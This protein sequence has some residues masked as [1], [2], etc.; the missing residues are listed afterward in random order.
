MKKHC[1]IFLLMAI[2]FAGHA[3]TAVYARFIS[4]TSQVLK[5]DGSVASGA[6]I[7]ANSIDPSSPELFKITTLNV[8]VEQT[9]NIGSQAT[10]A[11]AGKITFNPLSFSRPVDGASPIFFQNA[12]SGTPY[13]TIEVF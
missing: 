8:D 13:R 5:T 7:T 10:G 12:A 6:L 9:L 11:G 1:F 3:Q 4:Y 2:C